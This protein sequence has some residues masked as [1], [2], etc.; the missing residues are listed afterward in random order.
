M[1]KVDITVGGRSY[2]LACEDGQERHLTGLAAMVDAEVR[3]LSR[4]MGAAGEARLLL[5]AALLIADRL[6][7]AQKAGASLDGAAVE[8][9]L[10]RLERL[11]AAAEAGRA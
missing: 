11:A 6:Q 7:D 1:A 2:Q 3:A 9:A 4:S 8:A 10:G 5:M